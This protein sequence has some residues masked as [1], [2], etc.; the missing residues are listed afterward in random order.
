MDGERPEMIMGGRRNPAYG[1]EE[2][3]P[4][5]EAVT[6]C[7]GLSRRFEVILTTSDGGF[8]LRARE[9]REE[10]GGYQFAAHHPSS[11]WVALRLLRGRI[12]EGLAT[13]YL[14]REE[15]VR[16]L[17]H[18]RAV[19]HVGCGCVVVDGEEISF[20]EL[21][22]LLQSHEGWGFELRIQDPF[23]LE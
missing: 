15:G 5:T 21:T 17:G 11:P 7:C 13:R 19:G 9:E 6:D 23:R 1:E 3:F 4:R 2:G 10:T 12:A 16:R 18:D 20:E 22:D 8:F 14:I